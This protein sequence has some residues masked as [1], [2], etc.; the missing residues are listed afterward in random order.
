MDDQPSG[1]GVLSPFR[2]LNLANEPFEVGRDSQTP[3][4]DY[5]ESPYVFEG[6][7]D[8]VVIEAA[9]EEVVD[10]DV[11]WEELMGNQ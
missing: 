2:Q 9:G 8:Q 3:V 6:K 1:E 5:Y 7:I 10:Q 11:L 4:D